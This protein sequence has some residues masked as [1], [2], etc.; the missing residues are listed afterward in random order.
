MERSRIGLVLALAAGLVC[1]SALDAVAQSSRT[2]DRSAALD[3]AV[4]QPG[5][6]LQ[7]YVWPDNTLSGEFSVEE[8]GYVYLPFLGSV[9]VA[10][11]SLDRL[12]AQLREGYSEVMKDPVVT[13]TPAFRIGVLGAVG[14]PGVYVINPSHSFL[15]VITMAG[16]FAANANAGKVR[17][18]R[19]DKVIEIDAQRALEEGADLADLTLRSGDK[20]VVPQRRGF[21]ARTAFEIVRTLSTTILL[22][23]RFIN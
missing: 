11:M 5:D 1:V 14:R 16:G 17:I 22:V 15:D 21:T 6:V 4:L 23:E 20:I 13:V 10:G 3:E 8:T 19:S 9:Q 7:I 12:R 18:V 2:G